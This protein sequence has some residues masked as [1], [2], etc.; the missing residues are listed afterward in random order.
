MDPTKRLRE[1]QASQWGPGPILSHAKI[2]GGCLGGIG[3]LFGIV[4]SIA[5][6]ARTVYE[7]WPYRNAV[8]TNGQIFE[9]KFSRMCTLSVGRRF[10]WLLGNLVDG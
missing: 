1:R 6:D 10:R 3:L 4:C 7:A 2:A 5:G 8:R 9:Y